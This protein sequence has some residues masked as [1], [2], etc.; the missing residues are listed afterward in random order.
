MLSFNYILW[1]FQ[2]RLTKKKYLTKDASL[3]IS[4]KFLE[5]FYFRKKWLSRVL[6]TPLI[7]STIFRWSARKFKFLIS[8]IF[9]SITARKVSIFGVF[10]VRIFFYSEW[11]RTRKIPNTHN[12]YAVC[13]LIFA[14]ISLKSLPELNDWLIDQ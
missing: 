13:F 5:N 4:R 9:E 6:N 7:L 1:W 11:I 12:F 2:K 14:T 8:G 10:L 3:E